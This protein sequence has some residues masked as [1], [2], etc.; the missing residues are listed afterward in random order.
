MASHHIKEPGNDSREPVDTWVQE[1]MQYM[2]LNITCSGEIRHFYFFSTR[3]ML[4]LEF[5]H[6]ISRVFLKKKIKKI[7][8]SGEYFRSGGHAKQAIFFMWP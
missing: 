2:T 4:F 8:R 6:Q 1:W 5:L 7:L 3:K